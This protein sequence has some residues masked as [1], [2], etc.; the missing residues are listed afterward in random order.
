M[1]DL[2]ENNSGGMLENDSQVIDNLVS[3][4]RSSPEV[5][6]GLR[7]RS[8][9]NSQETIAVNA[10]SNLVETRLVNE[11]QQKPL[12]QVKEGVDIVTV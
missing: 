5:N 1:I 4:N 9:D 10:P 8:I 7:Y 3:E 11:S 2:Y 12:K 6:F